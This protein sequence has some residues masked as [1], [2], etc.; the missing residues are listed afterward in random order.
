MAGKCQVS[1]VK[2][3]VIAEK[4]AWNAKVRECCFLGADCWEERV[5]WSQAWNQCWCHAH[6]ECHCGRREERQEN[7]ASWVGTV[8]MI[9]E[10]KA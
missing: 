2:P 7:V 4:A 9:R 8:S 10:R 5:R 3:K 6:G 1:R